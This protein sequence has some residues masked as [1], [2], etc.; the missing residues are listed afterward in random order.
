LRELILGKEVLQ[1]T[2]RNKRGKYGRYLGGIIVKKGR[3][4]VNANNALV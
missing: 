4:N 1:K 2:I 3:R